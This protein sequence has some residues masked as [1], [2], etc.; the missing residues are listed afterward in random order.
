LDRF[1]REAI[2]S[3]DAGRNVL[4]SAPTGSGKTVVGEHAV[5]LALSG[6]GKAFYTAPIKALSNQKYGDLLRVL[7]PGRVGLL[8]GD[9]SIDPQAPVVVMTTEVLRNMVYAGSPLMEG[10]RWVVLDEVHFL[11]DAYRGPVWEEVLIHTPASVR[12]VCLSATVSNA[13][14][15]GE[16][17][18]ALRGPTDT[19]VEHVRPIRLDSLYMVGDRSSERD[20]LLPVLVAGRPNPEGDRFDEERRAG[21][22]PSRRGRQS[23]RP[24][25]RRRHRTPRRLEVIER[26]DDEGLLPAIYFLFSRAACTDAANQCFDAGLRLTDSAERSRIRALV[27]ERVSRLSD[28]DLDV[29]GYDRLAATL[30]A[31]VAAHHAGMVPAFREAVEDCFV[32][33][34]I[35]VVFATETLALGINMPARSV[36]IEKLTKFNGESHEFLTPAQFTQ[37]TGRAGRRGID[38]EGTSVVLWSPFVTFQQVAG[39]VGSREFPLTSAFRPTYNMAANLVQRYDRDTAHAVLARSFA[40]FQSDRAVVSLRRRVDRIRAELDL[41]GGPVGPDDAEVAAYVTALDELR[42]MRRDHARGGGRSRIEASLAALGPG[43]VVERSTE[44][45]HDVLVVLSVAFRKGGTVR[46]RAVDVH[47]TEVE[48][49]AVDVGEPLEPLTRVQLPVPFEPHRPEFRNGAAAV[50]RRTNLRR[51]RRGAGT[52]TGTAPHGE[53]DADLVAELAARA[54]L[55]ASPIHDAVDRDAIVERHRNR[56]RL[57]HEAAIAERRLERRGSGLIDR[58]DAVLEVLEGSG[59]T[60]GWSLTGAGERLRRIYHESDLL[61]ALALEN[62]LFDDLDA[63]AVAAMASLFTYEHRSA[64]A[65]PPP[66]YPTPEVRR[67]AERLGELCSQLNAWERSSRVPQTREPEAGFAVTAWRWASG[68]ALSVVL[69]DD[70]TGGDFVR[71]T[72]QLIDL[73]RQLGEVAPDP[74]TAAVCRRTADDLFRGVVEAGSGVAGSGTDDGVAGSGTDDGVAG[75]GTDDGR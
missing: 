39:L 43:D 22:P 7:G 41:A 46:V 36:V 34:L 53:A 47:A 70:M 12:F 68:R 74:R 13:S 61:I 18:T 21:T 23:G 10:L 26:L 5:S 60:D 72:K 30:E 29:L 49:R 71:N 57:G 50:L 54:A 40:Q 65:P 67:R 17:I 25:G 16:W 31:G 37:L 69:D 45:G 1:Q 52:D 11:Q 56:Q 9:H 58:F 20:H 19:V 24:H 4:V 8:T 64:E 28:D 62:G 66:S 48:L 6:D 14:E 55:E 3:L 32:E 33:G 51:V 35:K 42:A 75:S 2:A 44:D 38:A 63:P 15:L 27:E 59:H 73:L